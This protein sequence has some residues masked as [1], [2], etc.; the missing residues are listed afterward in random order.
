MTYLK[1][2]SN[3]TNNILLKQKMSGSQ[4]VRYQ[5][6]RLFSVKTHGFDSYQFEKELSVGVSFE[7]NVVGK[8]LVSLGQV[9]QALHLRQ[10][11][12]ENK[13]TS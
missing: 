6:Q 12:A 8:V 9:L 3:L 7:E 1:K 13:S 2:Q 10:V 11:D 4:V 5:K